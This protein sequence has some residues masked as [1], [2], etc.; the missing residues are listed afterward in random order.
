[1]ENL[2]SSKS[3][4]QFISYF[5]VGGAAALVEWGV[6][7][8]LEYLLDVPYLLAT[9][10]AFLVSTT[11]NWILGRTFTF[12]DS[13]YREK[14]AK[15]A[16][17]VFL[18]SAIGLVLNLILMVL[19]VDVLGMDTNLLKTAAKILATGLVF[20]WNFLSRKYWVY[21]E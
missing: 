18:V 12:R 5:G 8:M 9:V 17:L 14:K 1:M 20:I 19:F 10:L 11:V 4:R 3:V 21:R 15:E 7:S 13:A 16:F 6:F 2:F